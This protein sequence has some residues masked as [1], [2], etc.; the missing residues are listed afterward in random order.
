MGRVA[1]LG[2]MRNE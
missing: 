1:R 2:D